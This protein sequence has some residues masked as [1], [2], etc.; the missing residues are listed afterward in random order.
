MGTEIEVLDR[1]GDQLRRVANRHGLHFH[2]DQFGYLT[3]HAGHKS[4]TR[5]A[6][7][8]ELQMWRALVPGLTEWLPGKA[9]GE[10]PVLD[11]T[12]SELEDAIWKGAYSLNVVDAAAL[13]RFKEYTNR[14]EQERLQQEKLRQG[15]IGHYREAI[16][17]VSPIIPKGYYYQGIVE[18][19]TANHPGPGLTAA[20]EMAISVGLRGF[21]V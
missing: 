1:D 9:P 11:I 21:G 6:T 7:D 4:E 13:R 18:S 14:S 15:L 16:I 2:I 3:T 19:L 8:A 12:P 20:D 17:Y 5:E 10:V